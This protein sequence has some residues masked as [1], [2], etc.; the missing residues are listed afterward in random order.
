MLPTIDDTTTVDTKTV[1]TPPLRKGE[2][3]RLMLLAAARGVF[4]REGYFK[5]EITQITRAAGKSSG[6]F[7]NYFASK[8]DLLRHLV[9]AFREDLRAGGLRKPANAPE[10]MPRILATL[11]QTYKAHAATFLALT[12]AAAV[13]A[14]FAELLLPMRQAAQEDFA[15]M[16]RARQSIGAC[17]GLDPVYT[18]MALETMITSCL[19]EWLARGLGGFPDA[20]QERQAFET[21]AAIAKAVLGV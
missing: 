6:V 4:A 18:A 14:Q 21:L 19:H 20:A 8:D 12:E 2:Q 7:Y 11:W 17:Q 3:T 15:G 10:D 5:A 13:D 16:I 1:A 9:A